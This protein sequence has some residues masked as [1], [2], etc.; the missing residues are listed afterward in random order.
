MTD[1]NWCFAAC[2][3]TFDEYLNTLAYNGNQQNTFINSI[4][5]RAGCLADSTCVAYDYEFANNNCFFHTDGYLSLVNNQGNGVNQYR[6]KSCATT[7]KVAASTTPR[8]VTGQL[9][10]FRLI[11][12]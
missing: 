1:F 5:C 3:D 9:S 12:Q 2:V 10:P 4:A 11:L 6:R 7:L 8:G